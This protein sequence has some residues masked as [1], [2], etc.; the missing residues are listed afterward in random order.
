MNYTFL[1][2]L[3]GLLAVVVLGLIAYRKVVSSQEEE[4]LHLENV[5]EVSHQE[6]IAH[7]L[8]AID[9][10]GKTLTVIAVVSGLL[11]VAA[12]TYHTWLGTGSTTGL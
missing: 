7:K 6:V 8:D 3:W 10:W 11:L 12:Y 2:V 4:T 5:Q 1:T 9:K